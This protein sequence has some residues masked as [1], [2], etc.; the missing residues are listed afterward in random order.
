MS[1]CEIKKEIL[2]R[3]HNV[4]GYL[5]NTDHIKSIY[6][7]N[8]DTDPDNLEEN[9]VIF[10]EIHELKYVEIGTMYRYCDNDGYGREDLGLYFIIKKEYTYAYITTEIKNQIIKIKPYILDYYEFE[11]DDECFDNTDKPDLIYKKNGR[12]YCE[13]N[14]DNYVKLPIDII[15]ELIDIMIQN[16]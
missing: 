14:H 2:D 6:M 15:M 1:N 16:D 13:F 5:V 12:K 9:Y 10:Y 4:T 7:Y 11:D 8:D 3:H